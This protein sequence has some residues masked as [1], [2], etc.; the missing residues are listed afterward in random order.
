MTTRRWCAD[1]PPLAIVTMFLIVIGVTGAIATTILD[2]SPVS[3]DIYEISP[4]FFRGWQWMDGMTWVW[5]AVQAALSVI[6][7]AFLT[8]AY[9]V[10]ETSYLAVFEY[11]LL[12]FAA[13]WTYLLFGKSLAATSIIGFIFIAAAGIIISRALPA[14]PSDQK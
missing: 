9:Q 12:I 2:I 3:R 7:I 11:S 14:H 4:F 6:A 5:M 10:A 8:R 13:L 1:E